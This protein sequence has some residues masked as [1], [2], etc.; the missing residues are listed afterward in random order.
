MKT[1]AIVGY[2]KMGHII[3]SLAPSY[4]FTAA[5]K[6]DL[7]DPIQAAAEADV[8]IEFTSPDAAPQN[9]LKLAEMLR[10]HCLRHDRMVPGIRCD[11]TSLRSSG[12][13]AR[14]ESQLLDRRQHLLP[15][16]R[17]GRA[18]DVEV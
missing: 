9:L 6:I 13:S 11:Q 2:G 3:E 8:A 4:G 12:D 7:G 16:R 18:I 1:L 15:P 17:G 5:V 10:A 14:L